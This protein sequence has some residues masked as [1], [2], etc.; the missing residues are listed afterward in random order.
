MALIVAFASCSK[1]ELTDNGNNSVETP[2][3]GS[4]NQPSEEVTEFRI[5]MQVAE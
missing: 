1:T 4:G 5:S 2:S 3:G